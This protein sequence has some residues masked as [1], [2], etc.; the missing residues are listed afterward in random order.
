VAGRAASDVV[1]DEITDDDSRLDFLTVTVDAFADSF[2]PRD[3]AQA[4]LATM[5]AVRGPDV[6]TVV[7]RHGGRAV[8]G[9]MVVASGAV[10][11]LQLVGTVPGSRGRGLGQLCTRWAVAAGFE[12]GAQAIVLEASEAGEPLYLRLGFVEMSRYRWCFGP[13]AQPPTGKERHE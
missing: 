12:L 8:S 13:P 10:A 2:L 7:A 3:A 9:A 1:L 6:R 11:G 5:D 4:Q